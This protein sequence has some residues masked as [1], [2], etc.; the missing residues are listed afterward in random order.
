M[1]ARVARGSEG[2]TITS[3]AIILCKEPR[4]FLPY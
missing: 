2:V 3:V 1:A 4:N